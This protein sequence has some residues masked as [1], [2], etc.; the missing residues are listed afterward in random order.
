MTTELNTITRPAPLD[1]SRLHHPS[2]VRQWKADE[3]AYWAAVN[4]AK[5]EAER[6]AE[7]DRAYASRNL[8]EEESWQ[9]AVERENQSRARALE[10]EAA[11][12]AA[13]QEKEAFMASSPDTVDVMENTPAS[14]LR[15]VEFW[16][17]E[18]GYSIDYTGPLDFLPPSLYA[19]RLK[20]PAR[21][22][23]VK[24]AA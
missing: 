18:R 15:Q 9:L 1:P 7:A 21:K 14:L 10:R 6:K 16:V 12:Y 23:A 5:R 3:A 17:G 24:E 13:Q 8:T 4:A 19:V 11:A 22:K 20:R 2:T